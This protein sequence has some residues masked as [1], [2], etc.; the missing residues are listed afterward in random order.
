MTPSQHLTL[1]RTLLGSLGDGRRC[2]IVSCWMGNKL[3]A[4]VP[5]SKSP[6]C[7][8]PYLPLGKAHTES[9]ALYRTYDLFVQSKIQFISTTPWY[10]SVNHSDRSTGLAARQ[11][12]FIA[13][14]SS[15]TATAAHTAIAQPSSSRPIG[16][17]PELLASF[18]THP[19]T[20]LLAARCLLACPRFAFLPSFQQN[21]PNQALAVQ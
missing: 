10:W 20:E 18:S 5:V 8:K 21:R 15:T 16:R 9:Y 13:S 11:P 17:S 14:S 12:V 7:T 19:T 1:A 3:R 4:I 2:G 6:V